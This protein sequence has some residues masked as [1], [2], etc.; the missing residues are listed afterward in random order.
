MPETATITGIGQPEEVRGL[1]VT[2]RFL[3]VL[4]LQPELGRGF[5]AF[6]DDP[7][8]EP[9]VILSDGYWQSRFGGDRTVIGRRIMV[10]GNP[11]EVIGVLS[12]SFQFLDRQA[13]LLIP[14]RFNRAA[15]RLI[16]FCCQGVA[17][18]KPG[19]TLAQA[20]ADVARMLPMAPAKFAMNPG[21]ARGSFTDARIAPRLRFLKEDLVG[22][23]GDTLWVLMGAV[24]IVL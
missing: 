4:G 19:V 7:K 11:R 5:T 3:S 15:I 23:I 12:P 24:G 16:S 9:T 10:D 22:S 20:N 21:F 18:L 14:L 2:D 1:S 8:S 6:D 13:S 17:R